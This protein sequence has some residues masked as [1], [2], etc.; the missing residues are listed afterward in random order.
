VLFPSAERKLDRRR[1]SGWLAKA[2]GTLLRP[3]APSGKLLQQVEIREA[4]RL[5]AGGR[6]WHGGCYFK[7]RKPDRTVTK[8]KGE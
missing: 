3:G 7:E 1:L 2:V 6:E 4:S 8:L 5:T